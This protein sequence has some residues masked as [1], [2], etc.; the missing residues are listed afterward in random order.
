M[1]TYKNPLP[2]QLSDHAW[3]IPDLPSGFNPDPYVIKHNGEYYAY[4]TAVDGVCVLHS[5]DL[6]QWTHL[7]YAFSIPGHDHY[8]APAVIYD[9]GRFYLYV[10]SKLR[11]EEDVHYEFLKVADAEKPEGPYTYR[12]TLFETFSI[13]AHVVRDADGS[14]ILF[15]STNET[16]GTD[17]HRP[18]T[19]ILADRLIDPL[20]L[21]GKPRLIVQPTLDEEIYEENRFGDG[22][23]WHTI[24]GAFYLKRR[25]KHYVMYSGNAFT[26]PTYYIGYATAEAREDAPVTDLAWSKY[27][28]ANT[29]VPLLRQS[30]HVEGVGHNSVVRALNNVEDWVVY[31]GRDVLRGEDGKGELRQLRIDPLWWNGDRMWVPGPTHETAA[32]PAVPV[33]LERFDR[34]D[35]ETLGAEWDVRSGE[36]TVRGEEAVQL[37]TIGVGEAFVPGL[38]SCAVYEANLC[39]SRHHMGGVYGVLVNYGNEQNYSEVVLDVGRREVIFAD[40]VHGVRQQERAAQVAQGFRFDVYHQLIVRSLGARVQIELDGVLMLTADSVHS[41]GTFGLLTRYTAAR[42]DGIAVTEHAAID[43]AQAWTA[44]MPWVRAEQGAW[45]I[46]EGMLCGRPASGAA[47]DLHLRKPIYAEDQFCRLDLRSIGNK[48]GRIELELQGLD[49]A[50]LQLPEEGNTVSTLTIRYASNLLEV[51]LNQDPIIRSEQSGSWTGLRL[52]ADRPVQVEAI[53]WTGLV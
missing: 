23:D 45:R 41:E 10:S 4:T 43:T 7:G 5:K 27:P 21:E 28:D 53:E 16:L 25:N 49:A 31:H 50:K 29:Y 38:Y 36:W 44:Y 48:T 34:A 18:G 39:W 24:E 22:R 9:N 15:Y 42:F 8:W 33:F 2:I 17:G 20:T 19:V 3:A 26:R 52:T 14:L 37:S 1:R 32:A 6:V 40:I 47:I 35:A 46:E 12:T 11:T 30:G 51:W 13:D